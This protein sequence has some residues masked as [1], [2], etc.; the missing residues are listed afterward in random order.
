[1]QSVFITGKK[2]KEVQPGGK[3]DWGYDRCHY[4]GGE[5]NG[6]KAGFEGGYNQEIFPQG[7]HADADAAGNHEA[8][9][10]L[11]PKTYTGQGAVNCC[12]WKFIFDKRFGFDEK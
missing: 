12:H 10:K 2:A 5:G 1:M 6:Y 8:F 7:I 11:V 4:D 3:A 9:G